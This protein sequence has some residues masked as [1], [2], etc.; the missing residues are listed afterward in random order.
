MSHFL[1]GVFSHDTE[2]VDELLAP[3]N[4]HD[5]SYC[6]LIPAS[7]EAQREAREA[8]ENRDDPNESFDD[9]IWSH[10]GLQ[11]NEN[12]E[13]CYLSNPNAKWDWYD[14]DGGRWAR[15]GMYRLKAGE[16]PDEFNR[17]TVSQM[18]FSLDMD[19]YH[20]AEVFWDEY[21]IGGNPS[22]DKYP[23]QFYCP[24]YYLDRYGT[25]EKYAEYYA[26]VQR[27][28]AFITPDGTWHETGSMGWFGID[29]TDRQTMD[30]YEAAWKQAVAQ[31]QDCYLTYV[32][33]HI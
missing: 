18:D 15:C 3:Y 16:E 21:V 33:C 8:Y 6:E 1:V 19:K 11:E 22:G 4:E 2:D 24:E 9:F 17:V 29:S 20:Q 25:K 30:A 28:Y 23:H 13:L 32:D 5:E 14:A 31:Y 10:D 27:P 26:D 7:E 12:G